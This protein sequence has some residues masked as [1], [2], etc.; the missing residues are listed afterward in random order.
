MSDLQYG[1]MLTLFGGGLTLA[2]LGVVV[3][4]IHIMTSI[5]S[6]AANREKSSGKAGLYSLSQSAK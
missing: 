4:S 5:E 3:F 1:V 6:W 2:S